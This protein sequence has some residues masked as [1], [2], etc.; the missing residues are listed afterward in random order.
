MDLF[1]TINHQAHD[2][3]LLGNLYTAGLPAMTALGG[4]THAIERDINRLI[5]INDGNLEYKSVQIFHSI[6]SP[7]GNYSKMSKRLI[8][9][10]RDAN[11][12]NKPATLEGQ[13]EGHID[14]TIVMKISGDE[15][16]INSISSQCAEGGLN[17][18][19][20]TKRFAGG[21]ITLNSLNAYDTFSDALS[22]VPLIYNAYIVEDKT[23]LLTDMA[24]NNESKLDTLIKL[25]IDR[26]IADKNANKQ[27]KLLV[28]EL[29]NMK[30][31]EGEKAA[32]ASLDA[33]VEQ[34]AEKEHIGYL[35]PTANGFFPAEQPNH[36]RSSR[37]G[38][39]HL[40]A[41]PTLGLA[42]LRSMNSFLYHYMNSE[43][44]ELNVFWSWS[45][46]TIENDGLVITGQ[47]N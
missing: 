36:S 23:E 38:Y 34:E 30:G 40:Y 15:E 5:K 47:K 7:E 12:K 28:T 17:R 8:R 1:L 41:E 11:D 29:K 19:I 6:D 32:K 35:V 39:P 13:I 31:K 4:F 44:N 26:P 37:S 18:L 45:K 3:N 46:K 33:H 43:T 14:Q 24:E 2:V 10:K 9:Y 21:T 27:K 20:E 16:S 22:S 42:R 25:V